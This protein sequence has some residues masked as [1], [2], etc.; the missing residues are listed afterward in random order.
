MA[1]WNLPW[2][3]VH[4]RLDLSLVSYAVDQFLMQW[5]KAQRVTKHQ[6]GCQIIMTNSQA[7]RQTHSV[8]SINLYFHNDFI[9]G[10]YIGLELLANCIQWKDIGYRNN[11]HFR[12]GMFSKVSILW[13]MEIIG[14]GHCHF[15]LWGYTLKECHC[16]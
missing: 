1:R 12:T 2:G 9:F 11:T 7:R 4:L 15:N 8:F 5:R 10:G 14:H 13:L 3:F 6:T 16:T